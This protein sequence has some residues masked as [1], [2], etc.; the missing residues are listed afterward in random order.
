MTPIIYLTNTT[1]AAGLPSGATV[2]LGSVVRRQGCALSQSG[3]GIA[4][5][6]S[7]YYDVK[8]AVTVTPSAADTVTVQLLYDGIPV[9]G[10]KASGAGTTTKTLAI[11]A[12]V[13][14][15]CCKAAGL[16]TFAIT[17]GLADTT[18]TI[19]DTAVVVQRV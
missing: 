8:A 17:T 12:V 7:G 9:P 18:V 1:P 16:I 11:P 14:Q 5:N 3:N 2:P 13:R 10:A 19:E 4:V 15:V 6:A